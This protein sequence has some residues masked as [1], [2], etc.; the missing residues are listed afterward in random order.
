MQRAALEIEEHRHK[1]VGVARIDP[2]AAAPP[3]VEGASESHDL[4]PRRLH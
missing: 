3:F 2:L 4:N 1:L